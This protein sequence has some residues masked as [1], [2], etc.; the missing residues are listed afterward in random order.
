MN[1]KPKRPISWRDLHDIY[2][3]TKKIGQPLR[4]SDG[5]ADEGER[6]TAE[7]RHELRSIIWDVEHGRQP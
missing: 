7:M 4:D 5:L 6:I 2:H 3:M 1:D